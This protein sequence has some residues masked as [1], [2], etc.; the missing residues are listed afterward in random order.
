MH[1][2]AIYATITRSNGYMC[3]MLMIVSKVDQ[4]IFVSMFNTIHY[5]AMYHID[6]HEANN[7]IGFNMHHRLSETIWY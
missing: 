5:F 6:I 1:D 2:I 7:M 4:S 3:V